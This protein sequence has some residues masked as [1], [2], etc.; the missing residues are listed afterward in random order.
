MSKPLF[1]VLFQ[2]GEAIEVRIV[3]PWCGSG[4]FDNAKDLGEALGELDGLKPES[5]YCSLNPTTREAFERCPNQF[6]R[7]QRGVKL[8][9][10]D[11]DI[12]RRAWILIDL[13]PIRP[14]RVSATAAEKAL[15]LAKMRAVRDYLLSEGAPLMVEADS[16]NGGHL[17]LPCDLPNDKDSAQLVRGFL[18]FLAAKFM[19]AE[20]SVDRGNWNAARITKAYGTMARKG[21]DT[22][23][24][25]HRQS[26]II[27]LP[28][29]TSP[30]SR[31]LLER[32]QLKPLKAKEATGAGFAD[33]AITQLTEW[34][35]TVPDFPA[36]EI[37]KREADKVIVIPEHCYLNPDHS[38]TSSG[39]VF[40]ADGGIGNACK[41][42]GCALPFTE[43]WVQVEK[44][45]GRTLPLAPLA[46]G[47]V[48]GKTAQRDWTLE[49]YSTIKVEPIRWVFRNLLA[50]GKASGL[51]GEPGGGKSLF[52]V[53]L[54]A[55]I[56][57]GRGFPDG[58][59]NEIPA[60]SV[61][62]LNTED[63]AGDTIK[64]RFLAAGGDEKRLYQLRLPTGVMFSVD[65]EEDMRRL[66]GQLTAHPD[67]RV[68]VIDPIL[69]HVVTE[70]EQDVRRGVGTLLG[71][72]QKHDIALLYV[73]HFNKVAGKNLSS[74][75]DKLS[76]AKAWTGL[77]RFVYAVML[78]SRM[79]PPA[80]YLICAKHNLTAGI[81]AQ[82]FAIESAS[83]GLRI[84]DIPRIRW[85]GESDVN[86]VELLN[87]PIERSSTTSAN[88]KI[89]E[90]KELMASELTAQPRTAR[91]IIA[92]LANAGVSETTRK[93]AQKELIL[94]GIM[95]IPRNDGGVWYWCK[96]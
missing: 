45:Y 58:A 80:H 40:H 71:L 48:F 3:A 32:M 93:R 96:K 28:P 44:R 37:T 42:S 91:E 38:G 12:S 46:P 68:I 90:A 11:G 66:D 20:V 14:P 79:K 24:R 13:D 29:A 77:P 57:T 75:L 56:T 83:E 95:D 36:I 61:L 33:L 64:P 43:W 84:S 55:R 17:L 73:A 50:R 78:D 85:T 7:A 74:P 72:L 52:T 34:S 22:P 82:S 23:E 87:L 6:R 60:S 8:A 1:E 59:A 88:A 35:Q 4:F 39:I 10:N 9:C 89:E 16:G 51:V 76:G 41:H 54:A 92:V 31:E 5:I 21:K 81:R 63:G 19:D 70:K 27:G 47:I 62:M 94:E 49:N 69:Q 65:D 30:V 67:I 2:P 15:A 26:G 53:D 25:P 86:M 18:E